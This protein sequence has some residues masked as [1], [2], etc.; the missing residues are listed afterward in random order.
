LKNK[1]FVLL[2]VTSTIINIILILCLGSHIIK[3]KKKLNIFI[4]LLYNINMFKLSINTGPELSINTK[5]ELSINTGIEYLD[6]S[7]TTKS[8]QPPTK[9]ITFLDKLPK[10]FQNIVEQIKDKTYG[11]KCPK[12]K[13]VKSGAFGSIE[14]SQGIVKKLLNLFPPKTH[15]ILITQYKGDKKKS[16]LHFL[17]NRLNNYCKDIRA[18][19][20]AAKKIFPNNFTRIYK[21]NLC[22]EPKNKTSFSTPNVYVEM[23]FG[24]GQTLKE[25]LQKKSITGNKL[26][27]V[28]IQIYYISMALNIKRLYHNDLKPA[29]III[30]KSEYP[31]IYDGLNSGGKF[32]K[33][34]LPIGSFYPIFVDYDL[35]SKTEG[36]T[37]EINALLSRGTPDY[38]FFTATTDKIDAKHNDF[39]NNF[40][41]FDSHSESKNSIKE[42]YDAIQKNSKILTIKY[43]SLNSGGKKKKPKKPKKLKELK[44]LKKPKKPKKLKELKK[45][46][47][48]K[49]PKK[50]KK[51][52]A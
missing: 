30:A 21:C 32:I 23:A 5:P 50:P 9:V 22:E 10:E 44:K 4:L 36:K 46:K 6:T 24:K 18:F 15:G 14:I 8:K 38:S 41:T 19:V 16:E 27:S 2:V 13:T 43:T 33:I 40:P 29:N 3:L 42:M 12:L 20:T 17:I 52:L 11:N 28:F 34:E 51:S 48:L 1:I 47:K 25:V 39:L 35:I 37:A 31:I 7:T 45:L 49:K 26:K